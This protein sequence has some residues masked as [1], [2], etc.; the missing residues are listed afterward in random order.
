M[1]GCTVWNR[2]LTESSPRAS[3]VDADRLEA[4]A[5]RVAVAADAVEEHVGLEH[6]PAAGRDAD[7]RRRAA[8]ALD[9]WRS[10]RSTRRPRRAGR[11]PGA[12]GR[13][14]RDRRTAAG[15]RGCRPASPRVPSAA[16]IDAYSTPMTPAPS[17][18]I[19]LGIRGR[20][21]TVVL[22]NTVSSSKQISPGRLGGRPGRDHDDVARQ[23]QPSPGRPRRGRQSCGHRGTALRPGRSRSR[24]G[25]ANG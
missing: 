9:A 12:A 16:K 24:S 3:G 13:R 7:R 14:S 15:P 8:D 22:S 5:A 23:A 17:T 21:S 1:C 4:Q 10:G 2:S 18:I 11:V 25:S 6:V 19:D 20:R